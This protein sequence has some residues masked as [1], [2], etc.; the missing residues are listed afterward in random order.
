MFVCIHYVR[1]WN[2][3][4]HKYLLHQTCIER[5]AI[6]QNLYFTG[7]GW[8][9]WWWSIIRRQLTNPNHHH[10]QYYCPAASTNFLVLIHVRFF[11][12][13]TPSIYRLIN[14]TVAKL[15]E[16]LFIRQHI[17]A[18][19]FTLFMDSSCTY[20]QHHIPSHPVHPLHNTKLWSNLLDVRLSPPAH[21]HQQHPSK[22]SKWAGLFPHKIHFRH[23]NWMYY[24]LYFYNL[25]SVIVVWYC[26][27][28]KEET[29][30]PARPNLILFTH[31]HP[32][33]L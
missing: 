21:H 7:T 5:L 8:R 16:L 25:M 13:H 18:A 12:R 11:A 33:V 26:A 23:W 14:C 4:V 24:L 2:K 9:W 20:H 15:P 19:R 17:H 29:N 27:L 1:T 6:I 30:F 31:I 10:H 22:R 28:K 3:Y 32:H